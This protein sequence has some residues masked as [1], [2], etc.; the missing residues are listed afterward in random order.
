MEDLQ[1]LPFCA[2]SDYELSCLCE[3]TK[4]RLE[5]LLKE[6]DILEYVTQIMPIDNNFTFRYYSENKINSEVETVR[7]AI[8]LSVIHINIRSLNHNYEK[9]ILYLESI[10]LH[11]DLIVL[12]EIWKHNVT[13]YAN[14]LK[15]YNFYYELPKNSSVGGIGIFV[16]ND[17]VCVRLRKYILYSSCKNTVECIC[18][19]ITKNNKTFIVLGVYRHPNGEIKEF[20]EMLEKI[21]EEVRKEKK[22]VIIAGDF[23]I[24]LANFNRN[25]DIK[26]YLNSLLIN[27]FIPTILMPTR[28]TL[29]TA[30][31]IDH[32]YLHQPNCENLQKIMAGNLYAD[33]TDHLPNFLILCTNEK[34][35]SGNKTRKMVR[36]M[37]T[38]HMNKFRSHLGRTDWLVLKDYTDVESAYKCF[39]DKIIEEYEKCFPLV[40]CSRKRVKDKQWI[41]AGIKISS[42]VKNRLYKKWIIKRRLSDKMKY[43]NYVKIFKKCVAQSRADYYKE[44]FSD[45]TQSIK[46]MWNHMGHIINPD[47]HRNHM[48]SIERLKIDNQLVSDPQ[49]I[50]DKINNYFCSVGE[51]LANSLPVSKRP[52][53]DYMQTRLTNSM[54]LTP[55]TQV[56]IIDEIK[57]LRPRKAPG[58]DN[59]TPK[60]VQFNADLLT[61]PL[62]YI[63]NLSV[64]TGTVPS[65]LKISKV[66]PIYK[67][68]DLHEP[69]NYRPV[70]LLSIFDKI[71]EK[72]IYKRVMSF[73]NSHD[74]LN[75]NQFG[76]RR[77]H[78]TTLAV[79]ELVDTIYQ[80]LDKKQIVV[81]I[82]LDLKKA[83]DTVNHEILFKKLQNYGIRGKTLEWFR[84]Y[85][86][87]RKQYT[88]VN[89]CKSQCM[90]I[91]CGVPQGSVLGPLL[92]L[93]YVNDIN[94]AVTAETVKLYADDTNLFIS[95]SNPDELCKRANKTLASLY[96]WF[97]ANRL[98]LSFDKTLYSIFQ[99]NK[100]QDL[101]EFKLILNNIEIKRENCCMYLG[102]MLDNKLKWKNHIEYIEKKLIKFTSLFYKIRQKLT[103]E[104][105]KALYYAMIYPHICYAVEL[106]GNASDC[107]LHKLQMLQNKILRILQ[108]QG[109]R[110]PTVMLYKNYNTF[111]INDLHE[112][113]L[114]RITHKIIYHPH[115]LPGIFRNYL[116]LH[117][118]IHDHNT[119]SKVNLYPHYIRTNYG[120]KDLKYKSH[121]LWNV[122]PDEIKVPS[123]ISQFKSKLRNF[124]FTRYS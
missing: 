21:L 43:D 35:R 91:N 40:Q 83:F 14:I 37:T 102:V 44:I 80:N 11:F 47:K 58:H 1:Y 38:K 19:K 46:N 115:E 36:L 9:L 16:R 79:L 7:N 2:V 114:L 121:L 48:N 17:V 10:H 89:S 70:S 64:E 27:D 56:E 63:Y 82:Y 98:S 66:I 101:A 15:D 65:S 93:L 84:S 55:I 60:I 68:G 76:F 71:L 69:S 62:M 8:G 123:S 23:N 49:Q 116:A 52:F 118:N 94:F 112:Q 97:L 39:N 122:L 108:N 34:Q 33:I 28:I 110:Y 105:R 57:N 120:A 61:E 41:T 12:S 90:N 22:Y 13:F 3:S 73:L 30:T 26:N 50:A 88:L 59:I 42:K 95:D 100:S 5:N 45:R 18:L 74:I 107:S 78:S 111:K 6:N 32:I 109:P 31:L 104:C 24:N 53:S 92:F 106:Y 117:N 96:Q 4:N 103:P 119:R 85:L 77:K 99:P 86:T 72:L 54:F 124:Y 29:N 87:G 67:K 81:G 75:K 113:S 51:H 25:N 20:V